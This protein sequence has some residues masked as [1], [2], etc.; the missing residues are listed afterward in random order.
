MPAVKVSA[1]ERK[2]MAEDDARTLAAAKVIEG[3]KVRLRKAQQAAKRMA[4]EEAQK[5]AALRNV[6]GSQAKKTTKRKTKRST[7]NIQP[8]NIGQK[9]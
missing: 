9:I 7:K 8:Y 5:A 4:D 1:Q 2:W 3:D 6:A